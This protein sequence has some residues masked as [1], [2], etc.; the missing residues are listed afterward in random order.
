VYLGH[1]DRA[2]GDIYCVNPVHADILEAL[3]C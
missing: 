1:A 3:E 2:V